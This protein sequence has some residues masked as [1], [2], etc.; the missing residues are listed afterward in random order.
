M[1]R[2]NKGSA[3]FFAKKILNKCKLLTSFFPEVAKMGIFLFSM[4]ILPS[5]KW[6]Y[7]MNFW[8]GSILTNGKKCCI[9]YLSMDIRMFTAKQERRKGV[10]R[11]AP[12]YSPELAGQ[13]YRYFI[14]YDD[15][16]APSFAK[17]AR[18]MGLTVADIERFRKVAY[19]DR[20]YRE[21]MEIRRDYLIDRALDKR[22]DPSFTKH[23]ISTEEEAISGGSDNDLIF[24]LE[25][26]D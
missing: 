24:R 2:T 14:G 16:G 9:I 23:L 8:K 22:F 17:F 6:A 13:M 19:F 26:S 5:Q 15:R 12:K 21:C 10:K 1:S 4:Y 11:K 18:T 3:H 25:V 20:A 7:E